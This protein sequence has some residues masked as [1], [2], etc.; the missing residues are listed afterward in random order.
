[1]TYTTK[2][3]ADLAGV[4]VRTLHHYDQIGLLRPQRTRHNNYRRYNQADLLRLQQILFY[5]ALDLPLEHIKNI[6]NDKNFDPLTALLQHRAALQQR[7]EHLQQLLNTIDQTIHALK[8]EIPMNPNTLFQGF[9]PEQEAHYHTQAEAQWGDTPQFKE[10]TRRWKNYTP[11]QKQRI[12]QDGQSVYTDMLAAM[13][14]GANSPQVQAIVQR[15]HQHL[16][17]FYEP[18]PQILLGL[19]QMY[20]QHPEFRATFDAMHPQLAIFMG[21]AVTI[22]CQNLGE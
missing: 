21:E 19:G 20:S 22:Y 14:H 3:L 8:G 11:E 18:T 2:Q 1:M 13:P 9:T 12:L 15:W 7:A 4:S 16:R 17:S 10:S 6:L 5:R